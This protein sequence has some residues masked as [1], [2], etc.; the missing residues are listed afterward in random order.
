MLLM[1]P[2]IFRRWSPTA[3]I[4]ALMLLIVPHAL[5]YVWTFST[6]GTFVGPLVTGSLPLAIG[7]IPRGL[8][9]LWIDRQYGLVSYSPIYLMLPACF[10]A[11]W[12]DISWTAVP[13]ASVVVPAAAF[14][15]WWAGFAPA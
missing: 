4:V 12:A 6:W 8:A 10:F 1:H 7:D 11:A 15:E 3:R 13:V 2:R 5:F 14:V 9:G